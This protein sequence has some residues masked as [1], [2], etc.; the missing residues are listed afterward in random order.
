MRIVLVDDHRVVR[1]GIRYML[2]DEEAIEIVADVGSGAELFELL[3][4]EPVDIVLLDLMLPGMDGLEVCRRLRAGGQVPIL[5][6]TAKDSINDRRRRRTEP[7]LTISSMRITVLFL[8]LS[9]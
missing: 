7:V 8:P 6:I 5:I 1:D 3:E 4:A 2:S 9:Y